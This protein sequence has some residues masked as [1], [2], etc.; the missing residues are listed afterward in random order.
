M[1]RTTF[2]P[3]P[4]LFMSRAPVCEGL[5]TTAFDEIADWR[6]F[7]LVC[8]QSNAE[9]QEKPFLCVWASTRER[10]LDLFTR[11]WIAEALYT[12]ELTHN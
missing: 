5:A 10:L 1:M 6:N 2:N 8:Y 11:D 3:L 12:N 4:L 7:T 9:L